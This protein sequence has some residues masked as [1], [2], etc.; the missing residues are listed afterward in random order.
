MRR[1]IEDGRALAG[2]VVTLPLGV[3]ATADGIAH[4]RGGVPMP[5]VCTLQGDDGYRYWVFASV[6][7]ALPA[8]VRRESFAYRPGDR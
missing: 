1:V 8:T 5:D 6:V 7:A 2:K 4:G 3:V